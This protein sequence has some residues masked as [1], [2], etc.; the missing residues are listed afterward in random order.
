MIKKEFILGL[1]KR[2]LAYKY[3]RKGNYWYCIENDI[4]R[5]INIQVSQWDQNDYFVEIGIANNNNNQMP[6][7]LQW[8]FRYHCIGVNGQMCPSV[9]EVIVMIEQVLS[10]L[11]CMNDVL[12]QLNEL[13]TVKVGNQFHIVPP[14]Q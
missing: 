2:L 7:L 13:E 9:D 11:H 10:P 8:I 14:K 12:Q 1:T 5:C 6:K 4:I 3:I